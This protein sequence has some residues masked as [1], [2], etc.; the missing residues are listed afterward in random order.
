MEFSI[1]GNFTKFDESLG[2]VLGWAIVCKIDGEPYFDLHGDHIPEDAM[3]KAATSF[4]AGARISKEMHAGASKGTVVFAFP[5]T[6]EV[7][8]SFG[9]ECEHTGLMVAVKPEG[10]MLAK[11]KSGEFTGFSI[12][13]KRVKDE[14]YDIE[15]YNRN[16]DSAGRFAATGGSGSGGGGGGSQS[17]SESAKMTEASNLAQESE[18]KQMEAYDL[19]RRMI[20]VYGPFAGQ[21]GGP[22]SKAISA[23]KKQIKQLYTES[24]ALR[25][26][27]QDIVNSLG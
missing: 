19:E 20:Q 27:S 5:L 8:K 6:E 12:G 11:F 25:R 1:A 24:A 17:A 22:K 3:L 10:D 7:K 23:R 13:G 2:L 26:K 14:E 18:K 16:H 21:P 15:K 4:M 9:I